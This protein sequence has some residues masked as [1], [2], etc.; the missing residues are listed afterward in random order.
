MSV[1]LKNLNTGFKAELPPELFWSDE[2][3]WGKVKST[4]AYS[5]TGSLLIQTGVAK[6]GRPITLTSPNDMNWVKRSLLESL[7]E[8]ANTPNLKME[9]TLDYGTV[10]QRVITVMFDTSVESVEAEPVS[11]YE[12]PKPDDDFNVTLKF[13]ELETP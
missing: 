4:K 10:S 5:V 3:K 1:Y 6:A 12:S 2:F 8:W 9:L 13:L 11:K 7:Y